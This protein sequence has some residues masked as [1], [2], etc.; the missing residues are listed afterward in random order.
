MYVKDPLVIAVLL[1]EGTSFGIVFTLDLYLLSRVN[2]MQ[3]HVEREIATQQLFTAAQRTVILSDM[4]VAP[5]KITTLSVP[6]DTA[7]IARLGISA[8]IAT[9]PALI[10]L[11]T[12]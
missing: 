3:R 4:T 11:L 7:F 10:K 9:L 2:A 8:V 5:L 1:M 6:I 12:N